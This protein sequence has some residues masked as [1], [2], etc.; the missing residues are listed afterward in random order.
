MAYHVR[1]KLKPQGRLTPEEAVVMEA[2]SGYNW[3]M[4]EN[5]P[6]SFVP[7]SVIYDDYLRYARDEQV[8]PPPLTPTQ[9]GIAL[10]RVFGLSPDQKSR[11]RLDERLCTGI[12]Y[13]RRGERVIKPKPAAPYGIACGKCGGTNRQHYLDCTGSG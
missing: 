10:R 8:D 6:E 11:R 3:D 4:A 9:F 2:L 13:A 5:P 1:N 12:C 7:M